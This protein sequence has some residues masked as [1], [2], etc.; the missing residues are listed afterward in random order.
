MLFNAR[1]EG[2]RVIDLVTAL[3]AIGSSLPG[4]QVMFA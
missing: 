3:R 4:D 1:S 2:K